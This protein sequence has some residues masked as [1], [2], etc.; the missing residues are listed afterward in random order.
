MYTL[1]YVIFV[2]SV[3]ILVQPAVNDGFDILEGVELLYMVNLEIDLT[4]IKIVRGM[5]VM[6]CP[7][8]SL[9]R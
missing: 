4:E 7:N 9:S 5:K 2:K 1:Y 3:F 6:Y 8:S